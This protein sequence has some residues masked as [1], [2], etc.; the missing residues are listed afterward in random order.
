MLRNLQQLLGFVS[1]CTKVE[2]G[3]TD[4]RPAWRVEKGSKRGPWLKPTGEGS[5]VLCSSPPLRS[6]AGPG[7][8]WDLCLHQH[9]RL[10]PDIRTYP[11]WAGPDH[12]LTSRGWGSV[13]V[14]TAGGH[15]V[16]RSAAT[17]GASLV[18]TFG[19]LLCA[20]CSVPSVCDA[21]K[22]LKPRGAAYLV[23]AT[24]LS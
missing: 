13:F 24:Q 11:P 10:W 4:R 5:C 21:L 15:G 6:Q 23:K 7:N 1:K 12:T 14:V 18:L 22:R 9:P 17:A 19:C 2:A 20:S 8:G 3:E 16:T